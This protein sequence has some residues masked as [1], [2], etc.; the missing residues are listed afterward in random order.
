MLTKEEFDR[1]YAQY[2]DGGLDEQGRKVLAPYRVDNAV[3]LAAGLSARFAPLSWETPK[4]LLT[5][6]GEVLIERQIRQLHEAG[7]KDITLVVGY[8]AEKFYYLREKLGVDIVENPDYARY[9]NTS[10]LIR[11]T[12]RLKN[13]YLC[14][15]DNFFTE[16]LFEPYV[17]DS[18]YASEF[19]PGQSD[20]WGLVCAADGRITGIDHA[21]CDCWCMLGQV[22]FSRSFSERLAA[23]LEREYAVR[24]QTR[25]EL[26]EC[27]LER[28]LDEL[29]IYGRRYEPGVIRE[30]DTLAELR[31]FDA[32]YL[33]DS[34]SPALQALCRKLGCRESELGDIRGA[35]LLDG[36]RTFSY[37]YR[38]ETH[39]CAE[40]KS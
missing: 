17:Y 39:I 24:E 20:E 25:K 33:D 14:S 8:M 1:L 28:H 10:S 2:R 6:R 38:G 31:A 3:I 26:W 27:L 12:D 9:N 11:V 22:Y 16:N 7:V 34:G 4:G 19:I 13:S 15:S 37:T 36:R 21:P 40:E 32:R 30:F 18:Y 35:A 23:L 5:V 29:A